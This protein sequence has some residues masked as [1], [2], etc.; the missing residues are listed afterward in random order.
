MTE[1]MTVASNA[2]R[3]VQLMAVSNLQETKTVSG[4][5]YMKAN[6]HVLCLLGLRA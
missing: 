3:Q 6:F 4:L 2:E 1:E 5:Q